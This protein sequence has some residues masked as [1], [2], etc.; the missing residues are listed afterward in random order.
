MLAEVRITAIT[1]QPVNRAS[2]PQEAATRL[3]EYL[4]HGIATE[5]LRADQA[6]TLVQEI[7]KYAEEINAA[8]FGELFGHMQVILSDRQTLSVVKMFDPIKKYPTRSIPGTLSLLEANADLWGLP[9]RQEL[10]RMIIGAGMEISGIE[11]LDNAELTRTLVAYYR[12]ILPDS[13]AV[14]ADPDELSSSLVALLQHRD[15]LIA[16]NEA[17]EPEKLKEVTW[18]QAT[19]LVNYAKDYVSAVGLGYLGIHFGGGGD[20]YMLTSD[21]SRTVNGL[22]RLLRVARIADNPHI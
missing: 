15:K 9:R 12:N 6:Y 13:R 2:N 14:D 1:T 5:I 17:I 20:G 3:R 4:L 11:C 18:G 7:G 22:R 19:S 10:E 21:A 8:N 16:H